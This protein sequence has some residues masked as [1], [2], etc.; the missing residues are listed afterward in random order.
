[1]KNKKF[2]I[3]NL[4]IALLFVVIS[5]LFIAFLE[6]NKPLGLVLFL[7]MLVISFAAL[8]W[9]SYY[10][11]RR[12]LVPESFIM[13][14]VP[15][16]L[17]QLVPIVT[18]FLCSDYFTNGALVMVPVLFMLILT[19][20]YIGVVFSLI[21]YNQKAVEDE[22]MTEAKSNKVEDEASYYN[23]DGSFKGLK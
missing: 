11:S 12:E 15:T 3:M 10:A 19:I 21:Y 14:S 13:L 22:K 8:G 5:I 20:I 23:E 2:L 1:M 7:L 4:L 6:I 16:Y 9:F 17:F 18:F